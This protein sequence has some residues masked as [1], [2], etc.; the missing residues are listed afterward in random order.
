MRVP[1]FGS[2]GEDTMKGWA[3][4]AKRLGTF[5]SAPAHLLKKSLDKY[6]AH[7]MPGL[8]DGPVKSGRNF[9]GYRLVEISWSEDWDERLKALR[10]QAPSALVSVHLPMDKSAKQKAL[11]LARAGVSIIHLEASYGGR[12]VDDESTTMKDVLRSVH[13]ILIDDGIRD[14]MTLLASG[15]IAMAEHVAKAILCGADAVLIDFPILIALECRMCRRCA[16]GLSCPVEIEKATPAWVASRVYNLFGAFHNQL[17]EVMGAMGIRDVRRLRGEVGRAM[18]F[19]ELDRPVFG[20]LGEVKE[21]Y[22]LE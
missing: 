8:P 14:E 13:R 11:A 20:T 2:I 15:G 22:E 12:A 19:E 18:F 1:S 21:G 10:K 6:R 16:S 4:A 9:K 3:M 7:F 5:L 17:L